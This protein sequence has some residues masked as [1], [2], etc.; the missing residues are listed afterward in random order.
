M[1]GRLLLQLIFTLGLLM[2]GVIVFGWHALRLW[3]GRGSIDTSDIR[4]ALPK[5]SE[6]A[7]PK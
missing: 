4:H 7:T 2:F 3:E 1:I 5:A 6:P